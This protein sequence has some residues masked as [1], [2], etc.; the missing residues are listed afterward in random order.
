MTSTEPKSGTGSL[1]RTLKSLYGKR[2]EE[3]PSESRQ[4]DLTLRI[5]LCKWKMKPE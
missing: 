3:M 2:D 5:L 1:K 4:S